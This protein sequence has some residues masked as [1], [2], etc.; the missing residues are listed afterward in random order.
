MRTKIGCIFIVT[1]MIFTTYSYGCETVDDA[2]LTCGCSPLTEL[3]IAGLIKKSYKHDNEASYKLYKY[4]IACKREFHIRDITQRQ[5]WP[6]LKKSASDGNIAAQYF[7]SKIY[8]G[9]VWGED[10]APVNT[11]KGVYWLK[12]AANNGHEEAK[13]E[14]ESLEYKLKSSEK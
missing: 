1:L 2:F 4:Y 6:W 13:K 9:E 10:E 14:L 5:F 7:L 8:F 3:E 12:K 11:V